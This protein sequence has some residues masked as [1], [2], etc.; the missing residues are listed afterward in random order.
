MPYIKTRTRG[1]LY[2]HVRS[3][4]NGYVAFFNGTQYPDLA[5]TQAAGSRLAETPEEALEQLRR[6]VDGD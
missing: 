6:A 2:V 5:G 3:A 4:D 1:T